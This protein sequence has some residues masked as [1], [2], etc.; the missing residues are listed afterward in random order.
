[1]TIGVPRP[2]TDL[3]NKINVSS[4]LE[5]KLFKIYSHYLRFYVKAWSWYRYDRKNSAP[6]YPL[7]T[8]WIDPEEIEHGTYRKQIEEIDGTL[9]PK[10]LDG[11]WDQKIY[12]IE[13]E[14]PY[15]SM[16]KHFIEGEAWE[17]TPRYQNMLEKIEKEGKAY[18]GGCIRSE[19][20]LK[21][22]FER[23]DQLYNNI[24]DNGY[25]SQKEIRNKESIVNEDLRPEHYANELNE[26]VID[27]GREGEILF[28]EGRHR[29]VMAKLLCLEKIPVRALVRHSKW[30]QKRNKA[31]KNPEKLSEEEKKHP[32][33]QYLVT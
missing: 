21:E 8:F 14:E 29:L 11:D 3:Y 12:R 7:K 28:E 32:D 9:L 19:E 2:V 16:K 30:Q 27:I 10:V 25:L 6:L 18:Y 1:M 13:D 5:K 26:V 22:I 17:K 24:S 15:I 23:I 20:K 31:V 33:I 4:S